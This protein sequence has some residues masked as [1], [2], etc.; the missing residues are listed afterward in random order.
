MDIDDTIFAVATARGR[1]GVAVVRV[2]GRLAHDAVRLLVGDLPAPRRTA[3]RH[4]R[5]PKSGEVIDQALVLIFED[6]KSFTG[7]NRSASEKNANTSVPPMKPS[8]TAD[9]T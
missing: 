5:D 9:V 6:G 4:I 2:S 7:E 3:L 1:A 8:I